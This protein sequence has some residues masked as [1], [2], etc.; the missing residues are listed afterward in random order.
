MEQFRMF[1]LLGKN[2]KNSLSPLLHNKLFEL[3]GK[4]NYRYE[5]YQDG[6][7]P[8]LGEIKSNQNFG[9]VSISIPFKKTYEESAEYL[10]GMSIIYGG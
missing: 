6:I 2:K 5:I 1:Y 9:G 8:T 3:K 4:D 10:S 7:L